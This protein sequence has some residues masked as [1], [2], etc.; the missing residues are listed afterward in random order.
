MDRGLCLLLTTH[1]Q[2]INW[3]IL[4]S[5]RQENDPMCQSTDTGIPVHH[6]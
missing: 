6:G 2:G 1:G 4:G 3:M 5:C